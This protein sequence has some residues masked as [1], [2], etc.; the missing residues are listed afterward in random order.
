MTNDVECS[1]GG[2]GRDGGSSAPC[3]ECL[4]RSASTKACQH[5]YVQEGPYVFC[6]YCDEQHPEYGKPLER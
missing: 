2:S 3:P 4:A 1:C 5:Y 6:A